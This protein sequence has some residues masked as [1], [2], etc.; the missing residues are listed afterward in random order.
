MPSRL[1]GTGRY[2]H[3]LGGSDRVLELFKKGQEGHI[4]QYNEL[5]TKLTTL[6][7]NG[8]Y[9]KEFITQ[10]DWFHTAEGMRAFLLQGLS[11]PN[12]EQYRARSK[13]FA[14]MFMGDDPEAPNYD[15]QHKILR[16]MWTGSKG[17]MLRKATTYDWVGDPVPGNVPPVAQS[18]RPW[19]NARPHSLLRQDARAL[20]RVSR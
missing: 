17:P 19:K 9:S 20:R 1:I 10:S 5:R 4:K 11:D 16:S 18:R 12:D 14:A 2:W 7:A 6:A 15:K 3:A 13:R 8:A